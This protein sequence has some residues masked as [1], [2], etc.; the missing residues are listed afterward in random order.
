MFR[1]KKST[2]QSQVELFNEKL[3]TRLEEAEDLEDLA[4]TMSLMEKLNDLR[5]KSRISPDTMA[6]IG[7]N[8]LGILLILEYERVHVISSKALGFVMRG[9]V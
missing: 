6:I 2:E 3:K 1:R 9:R 7:G 8:L 5:S 4:E